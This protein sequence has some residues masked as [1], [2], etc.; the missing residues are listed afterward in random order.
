[1]Q[2]TP[3]GRIADQLCSQKV[4]TFPTPASFAVTLRHSSTFAR[5]DSDALLEEKVLGRYGIS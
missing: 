4:S 3:I 5:R 1:M 2:L